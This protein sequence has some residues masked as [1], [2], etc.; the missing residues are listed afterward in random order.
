MRRKLHMPAITLGLAEVEERLHRLRR[1]LNAVTAQ[2]SVYVCLSVTIA[3]LSVLIILALRGPA[4]AFRAATW[5]GGVLCL[6]VTVW[7]WMTARRR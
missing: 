1:R 2:H 7:A 4:A 5:S 6:T 3:V